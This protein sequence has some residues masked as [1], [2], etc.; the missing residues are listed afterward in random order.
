MTLY[1]LFERLDAGKIRLDTPL[2]VSAARRRPG[3]DQTRSQAR[4]DHRRSKTRSRAS[5]HKSANDAAV[6]IAENLGGERRRLRQADDAKGPRA[7]HEPHHLCQRVRPA[8]RRSDHH[9]ARPGAARPRD[10]GPFPALLQILLDRGVRLSRRRHAQSRPSA[11]RWSAASTASRP[12]TPAPPASTS[13]PPF[14]ATAATSSASCWAAVRLGERD[15]HMRELISEHIK[16]ASLQRTAP[17]IAEQSAPQRDRG[18]TATG[19]VRKG[20]DGR[21]QRL[22]AADS[23]RLPAPKRA[24]HPRRLAR[25]VQ[26][27]LVKT[28]TTASRRRKRRRSG[29]C[30][31]WFRSSRC[32]CRTMYLPHRAAADRSRR[33][34]C[35]PIGCR[36]AG[37][38]FSVP[39]PCGCARRAGTCPNC[40]PAAETRAGDGRTAQPE[41]AAAEPAKPMAAQDSSPAK[42]ELATAEPRTS[43][44]AAAGSSRSAPSKAKTRQSSI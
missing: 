42:T 38:R 23:S 12:A 24:A 26:P 35:R 21:A 34:R 30:R 14:I 44:R 2:K 1:L 11:R 17:V 36:N 37:S 7:R 31:R 9:G 19:C 6:T 22:R 3:A 33:A 13:S 8:E 16:E 18:M 25:S 27:L 28:V 4:P 29:R 32:W 43:V 20:A 41:S 10:P 5:S 39:A 40:Q 15:A